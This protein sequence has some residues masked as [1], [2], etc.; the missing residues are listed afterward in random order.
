LV[1][2]KSALQITPVC[3]ISW[4]VSLGNWV[5]NVL[6]VFN[7]TVGLRSHLKVVGAT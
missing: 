6:L 5:V 4:Y 1:G 3:R 7:K 2:F